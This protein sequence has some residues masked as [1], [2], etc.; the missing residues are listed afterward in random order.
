MM[1]DSASVVYN[2]SFPDSTMKKK[3]VAVSYHRIREFVA[4]GKGYLYYERS[5]LN[6][7]DLFA[8]VLPANTRHT[9][10]ES[11]LS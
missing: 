9:L 3:H 8:K 7:G 6:I 11:I 5:Q 2:G 10:I 1:C 4:A